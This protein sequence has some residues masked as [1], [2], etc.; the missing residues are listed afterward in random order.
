MRLSGYIDG[1]NDDEQRG[2]LSSSKLFCPASSVGSTSVIDLLAIQEP[3]D[4]SLSPSSCSCAFLDCVRSSLRFLMPSR[5]AKK[6]SF[7]QNYHR[8]THSHAFFFSFFFFL[9]RCQKTCFAALSRPSCVCVRTD[10]TSSVPLALAEAQNARRVAT[11]D[12][13]WAG[14]THL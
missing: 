7:G 4:H 5:R 1:D 3:A 11:S 10:R 6:K 12:V 13:T 9:C 8:A 2:V 14:Q